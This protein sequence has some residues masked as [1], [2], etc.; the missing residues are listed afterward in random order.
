M[1]RVWP[2]CAHLHKRFLRRKGGILG[3]IMGITLSALS[4]EDS[5]S[6]FLNGTHGSEPR[7]IAGFLF[8]SYIL[9]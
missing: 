3:S 6:N 2:A 5:R 1:N 7:S 8:W 4:F 9:P